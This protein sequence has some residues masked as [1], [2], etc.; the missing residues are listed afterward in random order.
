MQKTSTKEKWE[1]KSEESNPDQSK[2]HLE[3]EA[4]DL[5]KRL[6]SMN[7]E[8]NNSIEKSM[9][10]SMEKWTTKTMKMFTDS[11]T[12]L[13]SDVK[14]ELKA[15]LSPA[16]GVAEA[17]P[18]KSETNDPAPSTSKSNIATKNQ[19]ADNEQRKEGFCYIQQKDENKSRIQSMRKRLAKANTNYELNA[20]VR[21]LES[22]IYEDMDKLCLELGRTPLKMLLI[23]LADLVV[24]FSKKESKQRGNAGMDSFIKKKTCRKTYPW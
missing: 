9:E 11:I 6:Q 23:I 12:K 15:E 13:K 8:M 22:E 16:P 3:K 4:K 10:K 21:I 24:I 1:V 19:K 20:L 7:L 18:V 5:D 2:Y 14:N 17:A